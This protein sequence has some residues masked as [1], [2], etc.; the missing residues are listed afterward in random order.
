MNTKNPCVRTLPGL[1]LLAL[2]LMTLM[3]PSTLAQGVCGTTGC[4]DM[5]IFSYKTTD[6]DGRTWVTF[7]ADTIDPNLQQDGVFTGCRVYT[8]WLQGA[9][10]AILVDKDSPGED[11]ILS[12]ITLAFSMDQPVGFGVAPGDHLANDG[13]PFCVFRTFN[14]H[15]SDCNSNTAICS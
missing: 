9:H 1:A 5:K 12:Q 7:E 4:Y 2:L 8:A 13:V 6:A 11:K 15:R 3:A 10:P 14:F